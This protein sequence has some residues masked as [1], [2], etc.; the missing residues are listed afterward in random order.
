MATSPPPWLSHGVGGVVLDI[1]GVLK[2]STENGGHQAIPGSIE[3]VK[4]LK[5][6]NIPVR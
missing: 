1:F 5:A 4:K 2:N 6:A 3:A